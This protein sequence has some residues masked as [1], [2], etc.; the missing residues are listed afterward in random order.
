[1]GERWLSGGDRRTKRTARLLFANRRRR[2]ILRGASE[3][4]SSQGDGEEVRKETIGDCSLYCGDMR[5][6]IPTLAPVDCIVTDPPYRLTSGGKSG[7][8]RGIFDPENYNNN[9]SIVE[10]DI[11]WSDFM[12]LLATILQQGHAYVMANNRNVQAMLNAAE[13]AG[14]G[15]HNLLVWDKI[16]ATANRWYMKNCEF[17]G[18]FYR[19]KGEM[20]NDCSSK[21]LIQCP[22][23]DEST[24]PT[25]KPV[26][27][28][29]HYISNSTSMR[30]IVFDPFMGSGT[31]GVA[32]IKQKRKFIG[33]ERN[34]KYFNIACLR[35]EQAS[36]QGRLL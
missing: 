4:V 14:F 6:I 1:M 34:E 15:F 27:L 11:D 19:G 5:E 30:D 24:H 21:Q 17:T 7:L 22:Q 33:I 32:A 12:P 9:G 28:M 3:G 29:E 25:E 35:I 13:N 18:F 36:R 2:H 8:M 31:T 10:C 20:I 26:P 23:I 16:T